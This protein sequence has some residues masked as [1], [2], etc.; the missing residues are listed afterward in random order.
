MRR[1]FY[2]LVLGLLV[3]AL[4]LTAIGS[5]AGKAKPVNGGTVIFG[6]DQE[7]AFLNVD[8]QGGNAFWATEIVSPVYAT[9]F[10]VHPNFGFY[11]EL[12]TKAVTSNSPFSV[13]YYI[14]KNAKWSDGK[15]I[16]AADY[17]FTV[18]TIMNPNFKILSTTGYEDINLAKTKTSQ[19]GKVVKF[20]FTKPF[21][22]WRTL[23]GLVLPAHALAGEDFNKV[24]INDLN[25]PKTGK[26]LASGPYMLTSW[27]RGKQVVLQRN[28]KYW[29]PRPHL[30]RIV[31]RFLPD[32][33]TTATAIQSGDVDVIYPQPQ[34]FLVPLRHNSSVTVQI[35][36]G[37]VWEH[38]DFNMGRGSP[39]PLLANQWMRQ[40]I[41][42]GM[43]R[44]AIVKALYYSTDI[45]PGLPVLNAPIFMTNSQYYKA[46]FKTYSY[47]KTQATKLLTSHGCTKGGD[48]IYSCGGKRASF[49]FAWTSGNQLR[50]L[51]FEIVQAQLKQIG[52]EL[53]ADDAPAGTLFGSKLPSGNYDMILFAWVG[54]PD[55]SGWDDIYGCRNDT[56]NEGQDNNQG[57]C[58]AT[59]TRDLQQSNHVANDV[60]QAKLINGAITQ[61]AKDVPIIPLFQKPTYL[62]ARKQVQGEIENPTS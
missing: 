28:P 37:P 21:A 34:P 39:N 29:G 1:R 9:T 59:V 54:S 16:T 52:I 35:G 27:D 41:A 10:R 2:W 55:V 49:R 53:T 5:A 38:I 13:T 18:K 33:N 19:K 44:T 47:N 12:V 20:V 23:F 30:D 56:A 36:K 24:W 7:P 46:Q 14:K 40:A 50:Q 45:A 22:G 32:T 8:L 57:Y 43:D 26:P 11:P 48:G 15:P 6:A 42:Y 58:N 51:T 25:N 62:I 4:G 61:M 3:A 17:I 31:Y 60:A